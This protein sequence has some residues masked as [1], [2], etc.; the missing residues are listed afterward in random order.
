MDKKLLVSLMMTAPVAVFGAQANWV[1]SSGSGLLSY[2][3][4]PE[5][6]EGNWTAKALADFST[7]EGRLVCPVAAGSLAHNTLL[8]TGKYAFKCNGLVNAL[9]KVNGKYL[10]KTHDKNE[11]VDKDGKVINDTE[12]EKMVPLL[13]AEVTYKAETSVSIEV[14]PVAKDKQFE[15]GEIS[16]TLDFNFATVKSSLQADLNTASQFEIVADSNDRA[17]AKALRER[18]NA[19]GVK[20]AEIQDCIDLIDLAKG[21]SLHYTY[22]KFSLDKWATENPG[23][24]ISEEIATL[25]GDSKTYNDEVVAENKIWDNTQINKTALQTLNNEVEDLQKQLNAKKAE[26]DD[27]VA[28][29]P[30][31]DKQLAEYCKLA[32]SSD[33]EAAQAEIDKY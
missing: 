7:N 23:D 18:K 28:N 12:L 11:Y 24:R 9:I 31:P 27:V 13:S 10:V 15:V 8:P 30:A 26:V 14:V 17:E 4:L 3:I 16:Y 20:A 33:I 32:T 21:E 25:A 2:S 29:N 22:T 19:L 1:T 6:S 5:V